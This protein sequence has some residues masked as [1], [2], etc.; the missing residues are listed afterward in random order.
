MDNLSKNMYSQS[1]T[2]LE[3]K[4]TVS[5]TEQKHCVETSDL[6][7]DPK[8]RTKALGRERESSDLN[9]DPK[10]MTKALGRERSDLN[11][12]PKDNTKALGRERSDLNQ[13]PKVLKACFRR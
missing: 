7:Q 6:N 12:D 3:Q 8:D 5:K 13:D 9:Q 1:F 4:Q 10:D 2:Q 11:Q